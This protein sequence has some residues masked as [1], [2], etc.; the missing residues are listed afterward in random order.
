MEEAPLY[1]KETNLPSTYQETEYLKAKT[2]SVTMPTH[3]MLTDIKMKVKSF[4]RL[5]VNTLDQYNG[6][7]RADLYTDSIIFFIFK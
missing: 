2:Y 4:L 3:N 5:H 7:Y 1:T 6:S